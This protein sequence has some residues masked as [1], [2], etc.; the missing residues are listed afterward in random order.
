MLAPWVTSTTEHI[1]VG[2]YTDLIH[3]IKM[4]L[5]PDVGS[6]EV[7]H[8]RN[9][10]WRNWV[11]RPN[12]HQSHPYSLTVG[13]LCSD[14]SMKCPQKPL[15]DV[16]CKVRGPANQPSPFN[17][18]NRVKNKQHLFLLIYIRHGSIPNPFICCPLEKVMAILVETAEV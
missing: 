8:Q 11:W 1:E 15:K 14:A 7:S 3:L 18:L 12:K 16:F 4:C 17:R 13:F 2:T 9:I 5:G 6:I 10:M